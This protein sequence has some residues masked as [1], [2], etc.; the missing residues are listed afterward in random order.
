MC[1]NLLHDCSNL[2]FAIRRGS[3]VSR[4]SL[5]NSIFSQLRMF[6]VRTKSSIQGIVFVH[7]F[8]RWEKRKTSNPPTPGISSITS[9]IRCVYSGLNKAIPSHGVTK[10][11]NMHNDLN[12]LDIRRDSFRN[13]KP[14]PCWTP[15]LWPP[16]GGECSDAP[17]TVVVQTFS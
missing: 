17:Q 7:Q 15:V 1:T 2:T 12:V 11:K 10:R 4:Q 9:L 5:V 13:G 3:N 6:F 16:R 14:S 8:T